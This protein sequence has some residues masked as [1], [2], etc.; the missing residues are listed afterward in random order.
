MRCHEFHKST[1]SLRDVARAVF[2]LR[3]RSRLAGVSE[4]RS[5][6]DVRRACRRRCF[7][8]PRRA[9]DSLPARLEPH[10]RRCG[11]R[12]ASRPDQHEPQ[13]GG[14]VVTAVAHLDGARWGLLAAHLA[15]RLAGRVRRAD[16]RP[17]YRNGTSRKSSLRSLVALSRGAPQSQASVW[18]QWFDEAPRP[19]GD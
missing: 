5:L 19:P 15:I 11:S 3:R 17:R 13:S 9:G 7:F 1:V 16:P 10:P 2:W 12:L 6:A 14:T 18:L 4:R 8:L